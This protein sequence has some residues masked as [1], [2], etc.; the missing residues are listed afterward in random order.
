MFDIEI[1]SVRESQMLPKYKSAIKYRYKYQSPPKV[2]NNYLQRYNL[3]DNLISTLDFICR[4][5]TAKRGMKR[6]GRRVKGSERRGWTY[7]FLIRDNI[8]C[9]LLKWTGSTLRGRIRGIT[10]SVCLNL[11]ELWGG[12][13]S[14]NDTRWAFTGDFPRSKISGLDVALWGSGLRRA[15]KKSVVWGDL[16]KWR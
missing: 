1:F 16:F 4:S 14:W 7:F 8:S 10:S 5:N 2:Y 6:G 9:L 3:W 12:K 13:S 15:C 11:R